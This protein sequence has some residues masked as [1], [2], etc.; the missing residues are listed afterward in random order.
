VTLY[1]ITVNLS[2][3]SDD[4]L[5]PELSG[6]LAPLGHTINSVGR[7]RVWRTG[8]LACVDIHVLYQT[9][10]KFSISH[11]PFLICHLIR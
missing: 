4:D 10:W 3:A 5:N 2:T 9:N 8:I 1:S 11:F 7:C 6:F